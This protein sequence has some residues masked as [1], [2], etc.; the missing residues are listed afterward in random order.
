M[1]F[2]TLNVAVI[3]IGLGFAGLGSSMGVAKADDFTDSMEQMSRDDMRNQL[4]EAQH[5]LRTGDYDG[6]TDRLEDADLAQSTADT[7]HMLGE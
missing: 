1:N 2:R 6:A 7:W 3:A 4:E 5:A